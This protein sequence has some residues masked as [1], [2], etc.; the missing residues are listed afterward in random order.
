M[1]QWIFNI[2]YILFAVGTTVIR[3]PHQK[4]NKSNI[5]TLDQKTT[6]EKVLLFM[7]STGMMFLPLLY[8]FSPW[9]GFA[10]YHLPIWLQWVGVGILGISLW[11]FYRSHKDLGRNWSVS[12]EIREEHSL[13]TNGVYQ[14]IRHP[15]YSSIWLWVIAQALLLPN[16]F[17]GLGGLIGFGALYFLRVSKEEDMMI[18]KF[19][20][21]YQDY[22]KVTNRLIPKF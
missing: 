15:M 16:Y 5:I 4:R 13:I 12:L 2:A 20:E 9:L 22:M 1:S 11:L 3:T 6:L 18:E 14:H 21:A 10:D 17:A 8:M 19:G 7:V